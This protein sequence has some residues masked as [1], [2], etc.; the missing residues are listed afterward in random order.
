MLPKWPTCE[1]RE[2]NHNKK[3]SNGNEMQ[4]KGGGLFKFIVPF[5]SFSRTKL[6]TLKIAEAHGEGYHTEGSGTT[7]NN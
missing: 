1:S 7:E 4:P 3:G 2:S 5:C 6:Y